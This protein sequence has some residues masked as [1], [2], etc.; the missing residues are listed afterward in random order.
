MERIMIRRKLQFY[1]ALF[2]VALICL[3]AGAV[4]ARFSLGGF[5]SLSVFSHPKDNPALPKTRG[6]TYIQKTENKDTLVTNEITTTFNTITIQGI[7]C[8]IIYNQEWTYVKKLNMKF[9]TS[10]IYCF[11]AWDN[12]GN[13]WDFGKDSFKYLYN[14][15]WRRVG[16]STKDSWLAGKNGALPGI[17]ARANSKPG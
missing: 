17:I 11:Y 8:E 4:N 12:N 15:S 9:L 5:P 2:G 14:S 13:V 3:S 1:A 10:E 7:P 6:L 16:L